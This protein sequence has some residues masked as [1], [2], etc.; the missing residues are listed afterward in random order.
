[1]FVPDIQSKVVTTDDIKHSKNG[2]DEISQNM[3]ER[4]QF[5]STSVHLPSEYIHNTWTCRKC[6]FLCDS[7]ESI[8]SLICNTTKLRNHLQKSHIKASN[9]E[10]SEESFDSDS[11]TDIEH[12]ILNSLF[13]GM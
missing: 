4:Q 13:F 9:G 12:N 3:S 8:R 5:A 10:Y 6:T 11:T 7:T 1:V 2:M